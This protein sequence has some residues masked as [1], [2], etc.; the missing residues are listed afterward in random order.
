MLTRRLTAALTLA[1]V[2]SVVLLDIGW[3]EPLNPFRSPPLLALGS[4]QPSGAAHCATL[5]E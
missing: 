3:S 5:P 2:T 1:L 4:G